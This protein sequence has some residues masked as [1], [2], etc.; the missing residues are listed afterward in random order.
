MA[1]TGTQTFTAGNGTDIDTLGWTT[2]SGDF[3]VQ[4]N[5]AQGND[6]GAISRARYTDTQMASA[7]H[8]VQADA[9]STHN[10]GWQIT[11]RQASSTA[12]Y[13][14]ANENGE[15]QGGGDG[16]SLYKAVEGDYTQLDGEENQGWGTTPTIVLNVD[17]AVQYATWD[18]GH[19]QNGTDEAITVGTYCGIK[20]GWGGNPYWDNWEAADLAAAGVAPTAALDGPLGGPLGGP[21]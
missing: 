2:D 12:T 20:C 16:F 21:I 7:N 14:A 3:D 5:K 6:A 9:S 1:S 10:N 4:D 18:G 13:Y 19:Q 17:G 15:W 11:A 8:E